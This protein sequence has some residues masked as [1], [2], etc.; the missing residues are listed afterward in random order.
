[1]RPSLPFAEPVDP[2]RV[3]TLPRHFAWVDHRLRDH[4]RALRLEEI[5]LL[6][7]LHLAAD[8]HGL[9]FWS[10]AMIARARLHYPSTAFEV[11]DATALPYTDGAFDIVFN[12]VSLMHIV[13]Y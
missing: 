5:A 10:D 13:E 4:L 6:F 12:G 7:F 2:T 8:R 3:R 1:M 11:A 9:S